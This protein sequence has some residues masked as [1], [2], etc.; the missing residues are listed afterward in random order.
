VIKASH[1]PPCMADF[2]RAKHAE[3]VSLWMSSVQALPIARTLDRPRL[4]DHV[5]RLLQLVADAI[6]K[7]AREGG[8]QTDLPEH[9]PDAHAVQRLDEGFD[10]AA[11]VT[12]YTVLRQCILDLWEKEHHTL[13]RPGELRL[14]N[15]SIDQAVATAVTRYTAA[16][17]RT[18]E[19]LDRVSSI[20]LVSGN[21]DEFLPRLLQVV[22]ETTEAIDTVA[23]F[24]REGD[25]LRLRATVGLERELAHGLVFRMDEGLAGMIATEGRP[26]L[27]PEGSASPVVKSQQLRERGL[28]V[29][30]GVPL[31]HEA[32]VVGVAYMGSQT[33]ADFSEQDKLI[34]RS[35]AARATA[36]IAQ[37][38]AQQALTTSEEQ[39]R[40]AVQSTGLGT[41]NWN[42]RSSQW[43]VDWSD[44]CKAIFGLPPET[45]MSFE[46][47]VAA[48]HPEDRERVQQL[49][50]EAFDPSGSGDYECE[51]RALWP[52]GTFRW[53]FA[54]G[55]A[56]FEAVAGER[57]AV[58]FTGTAFDIT[59]RRRREDERKRQ[60]EHASLRADVGAAFNE[61]LPLDG[62]LQRCAE[63]V[64]G[65]LGAAFARVWIFDSDENVLELRASAGMYT[66]LDGPHGRVPIG[67]FKI[68]RIAQERQP[69]LSNTV[70]DDPWVSDKEWAR[71][72]GM[73]AFAGYPLVVEDRLLGVIA[74][75][76]RQALAS[77]TLEAL[78]SIAA[79]IAQNIERRRIEE[80]REGL[81]RD[82]GRAVRA[83]D[84]FVAVLSHDLRTPLGTITMG[85]TYLHNQIPEDQARLRKRA[86]SIRTAAE[87][88]TRMIEDLLAG[89]ALEEGKIQFNKE[90]HD[91]RSLVSEASE[92]FQP[93][94]QD[95]GLSLDARVIGDP[96]PVL[97]DR[98][99]VM[100]AFGNLVGNAK[101]FTL[102]GG[103]ITLHAE[104][105]DGAIKF[106]VSDTGSG[107]PA[108]HH[109]RIFERG[110]RSKSGEAGL[111]LGLAIAKGIVEGHGGQIG[112]ESEVGK[113]STFWF[114]LPVA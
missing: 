56:Y 76:S 84:D 40:L 22:L 27:L 67:A 43:D 38:R 89:I 44:R 90:P 21:L 52:D 34:L 4:L 55:K 46:R 9:V 47:F 65:H 98:D 99:S 71:R 64:V 53:V 74:L 91:P 75:F 29:L 42:F 87:R 111:G 33:A 16:R 3:I 8:R 28:R 113:G 7:G 30:Y 58:R 110:F 103:T 18:L 63:A 57:R 48:I 31:V 106:S 13:S 5:P 41:F 112:V 66:H 17:Q 45:T 85:A 50:R 51:Y 37:Q 88:A 60:T 79:V 6:D 100:R 15:N 14:L 25:V 26:V 23:V 107:I 62:A 12:E 114:T 92:M 73:A 104:A 59:D 108:E 109:S 105:I 77:D 72:E 94:A 49:L 95:R 61:K 83:R 35:M 39:L 102:P 82:L 69:H 24:L 81:V 20:A 78:G 32:G 54:R 80:D 2:L 96:K 86:E 68:G 70:L 1:D 11:V 93:G 10:L 97:C 19:A 101:K 36:L